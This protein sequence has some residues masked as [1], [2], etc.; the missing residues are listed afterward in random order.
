MQGPPVARADHQLQRDPEQR[1]DGAA[2]DPDGGVE[3]PVGQLRPAGQEESHQQQGAHQLH[4]RPEQLHQELGDE[5]ETASRREALAGE[6]RAVHPQ[7]LGQPLVP[8]GPLAAERRQPLRHLGPGHRRGDEAHHVAP[9][10]ARRPAL[11]PHDQLHVLAQG[12]GPVA[13]GGHHRLAREQPQGARDDE[14]AVQPVPAHAPGQHAA[15][16]LDHLEAGEVAA[17]DAGG[18]H[19]PAL[20]RAAVGRP[21]HPAGHDHP[22]IEEEGQRQAQQRVAL[23]HRVGVAQ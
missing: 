19:A 4:Q 8:A 18:Q 6:D 1:V 3:H 23:Q 13:A 12:V 15:Q 7:R 22:G 21:H 20:H 14:Q 11:E 2:E 16:V 10:L 17:R 9:A 5:G